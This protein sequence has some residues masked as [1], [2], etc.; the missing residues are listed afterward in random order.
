[1]LRNVAAVVV[2]YVVI[3][4]V[5]FVL[6]AI[7]FAALG[8][9]R[10][11]QARSF[12]TSGFWIAVTLVVSFLAAILGGFVARRI[13]PHSRGPLALALFVL[14]L[15]LGMAA[16]QLSAPYEDPGPR[17]GDIGMFDAM[18]QARQPDWITLANP[19]LGFVGVLI[20]AG[21]RRPRRSVTG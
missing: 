20:G 9:D 12:E 8:P 7:A 15:G 14:I 1:M 13:A 11:F 10:A 3:F 6:F 5:V 18:N 16:F 19:I 2:G 4:V 17:T 21:S